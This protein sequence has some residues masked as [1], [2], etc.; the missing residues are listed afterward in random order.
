MGREFA[1]AAAR[2][3]HLPDMDVRPEIVAVC[4]TNA[5]LLALVHGEFPRRSAQVTDD[6]RGP[7]GQPGGRGGLLRRAAPP[8][9]EIY[10][11]AIRAGKHLLGEKPFGIDRPAN[12]AILACVA[13][14]PEVL[15]RCSS[16]FPFFPA[17]QRIGRHDRRRGLRADHR[18]QRR[19]PALQRSRPAASRSTGSGMVEF[20]GRVRLHGRPGHARLPRAVPRRLDSAERCAR[21]CRTSSASGPDGKGGMAP[22]ETWD[23]ATLLCE[24]ADP[25]TGELFPMTLKTQRIAPGEKNTWYLEILG[26]QASARFSTKNPKRLEV[27]DYARRRAGLGPDRH[28]P[29]DGLQDHHRRHL[30][31]RLLRRDPADVGGVP[32]RA[33]ARPAATA[34][35]RLRDAGGDRPVASALHRGVGIA[36]PQHGGRHDLTLTENGGTTTTIVQ[37]IAQVVARPRQIGNSEVYTAYGV[38][39]RVGIRC[40][41]SPEEGCCTGGDFE[42]ESGGISVGATVVPFAPGWQ[43]NCRPYA[44]N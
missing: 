33:G 44:R 21:C 43:Y 13:E 12:D 42:R 1:S 9:R 16:E 38:T 32:L 27:L 39:E 24:A 8:A 10:C 14:H 2:W 22:C 4:D 28:G 26:T 15:V 17:V 40:C 30:R 7:A 35:C 19:L 37:R 41:A 29:R 3:C 6:Y 23:N 11:A 25:A 31:V 18:G 5:D 36:R 34:V 20:N